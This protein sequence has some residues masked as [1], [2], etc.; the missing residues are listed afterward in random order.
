M[1]S[2]EYQDALTRAVSELSW[3]ARG[4][5]RDVVVAVLAVRDTELDRLHTIENLY[6]DLIDCLDNSRVG[7]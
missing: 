2:Q 6:G 3:S 7:Q 1:T 5:V 4:N